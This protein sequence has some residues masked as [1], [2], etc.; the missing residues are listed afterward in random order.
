VKSVS[1][2]FI[3]GFTTGV[4]CTL[5]FRHLKNVIEEDEDIDELSDRIGDHLAELERRAAAAAE[6]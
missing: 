5:M 4:L 1:G 6:A 3:L 2:A